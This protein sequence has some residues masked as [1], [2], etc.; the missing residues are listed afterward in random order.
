MVIRNRPSPWRYDGV[1]REPDYDRDCEVR[2]ARG[3]GQIEWRG[4]KIFIG[5]VLVGEPVGL[6]RQGDDLWR[7]K[8]GP[9]PLGSIKGKGKLDKLS[10]R[11]RNRP[12]QR[13]TQSEKT[14]AHVSGL[15][16]NPSFRLLRMRGTLQEIQM[17]ANCLTN[18][19]SSRTTQTTEQ[20][21]TPRGQDHAAR[22]N[23]RPSVPST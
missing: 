15:I 20:A 12:G 3:N 16:C 8:Y 9:C 11:P 18:L 1:L 10:P 22:P 23:R 4:D 7:V 13:A 19:E 21:R 5:T 14:V 17:A 2:R 6:Y